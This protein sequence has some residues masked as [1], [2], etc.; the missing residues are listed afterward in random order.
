M[1]DS[2]ILILLWALP[3]ALSLHVFEEFAF[4]GGF[5]RWI[6]ACSSRQPKS[7]FYYFIVNAVGIVAATL[8]ALMATDILGYRMCLYAVAFIGGNAATHIRGT[9]QKKRYCPGTVSSALLLLPLCGISHWYFVSTGKVD[10]AS[11]IIC[12]GAGMVMGTCVF[13]VD[14]PMTKRSRTALLV[15]LPAIGLLLVFLPGPETRNVEVCDGFEGATLSRVWERSR[16]APG[17]VAMQTNI[18][19]AGRSAARVVVHARDKFEA[20]V[21]GDTDSERAELLEAR[22]L[23][24]IEGRAYE[25]S[26][27][28]FIPTNFP[29]VPTRVVIAQWKQD[30][31]D[32]GSCS[33]DP[34]LVALRYTSGSLRI[35]QSLGQNP[36]T[37]LYQETNEFRGRWLDFRWQIRFTTNVN[38]RI[39]AWINER[40][41]V[42]YTGVTANPENATTGYPNPGRFY[43]KMGLYR[44]L[45]PE[46]MTIYIDEYRKRELSSNAL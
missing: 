33:N 21:P 19:R 26:F 2:N 13:G 4:P 44:D 9:I 6:R 17:A 43:F 7:E 23:T 18:V 31:P 22:R 5:S 40:Q 41:V 36:R 24:S 34:P 28:M 25:Y 15:G 27:S 30:C 1:R 29:I 3:I 16:F 32:G 10:L 38:G 14:V 37:T 42:D 35:T 46:P 11:A 8:I 20:G 39:K 12:M 45:M